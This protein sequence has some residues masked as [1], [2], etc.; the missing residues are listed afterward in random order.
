LVV[1]AVVVDAS[2][3][4]LAKC[5]VVRTSTSIASSDVWNT[6]PSVPTVVSTAIGGVGG[7]RIVVVT[8]GRR[9]ARRICCAVISGQ[10]V[11]YSNRL[12]I[13][14]GGSVCDFCVATMRWS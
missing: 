8:V 4:V 6:H 3:I 13:A 12:R 14:A 1:G 10:Q 7:G 5:R 9:A 2:V 11:T